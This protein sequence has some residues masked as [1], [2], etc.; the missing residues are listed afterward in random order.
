MSKLQ[1]SVVAGYIPIELKAEVE[2]LLT[3]LGRGWNMSRAVSIGLHLFAVKYRARIRR[4]L[5]AVK[6]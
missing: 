5:K 1:K 2:A 4:G 3:Q 6:P